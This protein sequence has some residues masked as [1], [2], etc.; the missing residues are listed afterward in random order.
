M[1]ALHQGSAPFYE[2]YDANNLRADDHYAV[3]FSGLFALDG[4][5]ARRHSRRALHRF[6][7]SRPHYDDHDPE[8]FRQHIL[9]HSDLK[10]ARQRGGLSDAAPVAG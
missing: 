6:F 3:V 5:V 7:G 10:S 9:G 1:D 4:Q 8:R 2:D